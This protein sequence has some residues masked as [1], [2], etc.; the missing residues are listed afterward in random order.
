MGDHPGQQEGRE[1]MIRILL[2]ALLIVALIMIV[3]A[4]V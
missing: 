2:W 3:G 4:L 1:V